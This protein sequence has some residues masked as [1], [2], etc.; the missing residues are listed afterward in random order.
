M[1]L[2]ASRAAFNGEAGAI[3]CEVIGSGTVCS[4]SSEGSFGTGDALEGATITSGSREIH[5]E[6]LGPIETERC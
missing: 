6:R 1:L 2:R 4:C 5:P 3:S